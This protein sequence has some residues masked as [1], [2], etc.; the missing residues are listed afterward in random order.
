MVGVWITDEQREKYTE[1]AKTLG[2]TLS[3]WFRRLAEESLSLPSQV[4]PLETSVKQIEAPVKHIVKQ[5]EPESEPPRLIRANPDDY[6]P[7]MF[8]WFAENRDIA[9][10]EYRRIVGPMEQPEGWR[11][12]ERK[13]Q[14]AHLAQ[15]RPLS[16]AEYLCRTEYR[17]WLILAENTPD[18]NATRRFALASWPE[19]LVMLKTTR[20]AGSTGAA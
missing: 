13:R 17:E 4:V 12:W 14:A 8:D 11:T 1:A 16:K 9:L 19:R 15:S 20:N 3:E 10:L 18:R 6:W 2:E 7:E 5:I